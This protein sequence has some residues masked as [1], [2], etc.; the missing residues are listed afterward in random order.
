M[1]AK[2]EW[3]SIGW[4]SERSGFEWTGRA[5]CLSV[6]RQKSVVTRQLMALSDVR[7]A[8]HL[9]CILRCPAYHVLNRM[10]RV[11]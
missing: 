2:I 10:D 4:A 5:N 9:V 1:P 8:I 3:S 7:I 11:V 6:L